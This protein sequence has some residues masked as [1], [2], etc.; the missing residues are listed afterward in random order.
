MIHV[1]PW[2]DRF[3]SVPSTDTDLR[4]ALL[5]GTQ[6]R[7]QGGG[8]PNGTFSLSRWLIRPSTLRSRDKAVVAMRVHAFTKRFCISATI[9]S[10]I[11]LVRRRD[12]TRLKRNSTFIHVI[13]HSRFLARGR[14][15]YTPRYTQ[16]APETDIE[17]WLIRF[18]S[19]DLRVTLFIARFASYI[20]QKLHGYIYMSEVEAF[21]NSIRVF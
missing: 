3:K 15:W 20:L 18:L 1:V 21:N 12:P 16:V 13:P 4:V 11:A 6:V 9:R 7:W 2:N 5:K 8:N 17:C 14:A 19:L 10:R